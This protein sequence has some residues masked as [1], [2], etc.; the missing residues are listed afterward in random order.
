MSQFHR[1][2][3]TEQEIEAYL[4]R[5]R[6]EMLVAMAGGAATVSQIAERMGVHPANLSRHMRILVEAKLVE[7][8]EK[9]DTGRNLEK[10]YRAT[11]RSFDVAPGADTLSAP[12]KTA[13]NLLRSE[14]SAAIAQ[15][16]DHKPAAMRVL[17]VNTRLRE[18][19]LAAFAEE[20][21]ALVSRFKDARGEKGE[22]YTL[23]AALFP[24]G[25]APDPDQTIILSTKKRDKL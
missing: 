1:T 9:R 11:A 21:T 3:T 16:P 7:L 17:I 6:M 22:P 23:A 4:H 2:L 18:D 19:Q 5:T 12:H 13:L 10:Y 24:S 8:V 15:L 25:T 20:L 14:I